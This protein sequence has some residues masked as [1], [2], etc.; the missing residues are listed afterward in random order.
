[1]SEEQ[2]NEGT[3][4]QNNQDNTAEQ[5]SQPQPAQAQEEPKKEIPHIED[6]NMEIP[7]NKQVAII[8]YFTLIGFIIALVM[9]GNESNKNE[10]GAFHLRQMLGLWLCSLV[11]SFIP[12]VNL[13]G[14]IFWFVLWI[15]GLIA[16][17]NGEKKPVPIVGNLFQQW[18]ANTF[19]A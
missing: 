17:I 16:A 3:E 2:N 7:E 18:F 5:P 19:K 1:M 8:A 6:E 12:L 11:T 15:I 4:N 10:L 13:I 14:F 9:H